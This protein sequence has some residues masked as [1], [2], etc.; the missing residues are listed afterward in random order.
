MSTNDTRRY[1]NTNA[2]ARLRPGPSWAS[3]GARD[4]NQPSAT[5]LGSSLVLS[6]PKV[7]PLAHLTFLS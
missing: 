1:A 4:F 6:G 3:D 5:R 2:N 7:A